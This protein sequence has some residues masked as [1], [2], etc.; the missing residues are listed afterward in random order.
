MR[1]RIE[2]I[3]ALALV[4][5]LAILAGTMGARH[6]RTAPPDSRRSTFLNGPYGA[7]GYAAVLTRLG[8]KIDRFRQRTAM[9]GQLRAG[10]DRPLFVVLSP[11]LFDGSDA[12]ALTEFT[13]RGDL[14]LAG[15]STAAAM[16]C[17]G[18]DVEV[19]ESDGDS[20]PLHR[21]AHGVPESAPLTWSRDRI[22][23]QRSGETVIDSS[24]LAAERSEVCKVQ[25]PLQ[26][27]SL[28]VTA[29]GRPAA[30][31]LG[32]KDGSVVTLVADGML[33]SNQTMQE[34]DAGL[35]TVRIA[36]PYRR[37]IFDEF[38]HGFGPSGSLFHSALDWT[39]KSPWG[40][41]GWQ[42]AGFGLIA[43]LTGAVRFGTPRTLIDRKRRSPLEHVR[44]LATAL[45]AARGGDVA[46]DLMIRGLR[47]RLSAGTPPVRGAVGPWLESLAAN[48]K[49]DRSRNAVQ[50]LL[51]LTRRAS[52]DGVLRAANAVEDVWQD[53]TPPTTT[54]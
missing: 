41:F 39:L 43:L 20:I 52:P 18:Y 14:L 6:N 27:D 26:V 25:R 32:M 16:R 42:L 17:F 45:A 4:I 47:R 44:A 8:I 3:L 9:L 49:T 28:L 19:R 34:S 29:G 11:E 10:Q 53:L 15:Y 12:R 2:I 51:N 5:A 1:A 50:T 35:A 38:V 48:V 37:V 54:R 7:K 22:L 24:G 21:V 23:V 33:F 46:V 40:W 31:R 36:L 13:A 30:L